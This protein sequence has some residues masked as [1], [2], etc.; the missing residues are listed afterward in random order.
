M[1][2]HIVF[3]CIL[4]V[5]LYT[6]GAALCNVTKGAVGPPGPLGLQGELGQKGE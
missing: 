6:V 4:S 2:K 3:V 5:F 1:F